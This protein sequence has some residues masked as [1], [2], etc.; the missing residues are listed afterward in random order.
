MTTTYD[1]AIIGGGLA[2]CSAAIRLGQRGLRV[3]L[4][5]ASD[6]PHHKVC[7]EFMSPGCRRQLDELGVAE[8][9]MHAGAA[10]ISESLISTPDGTHWQTQLP[11]AGIGISRHFLDE[12]LMQRAQ[13]VGVEV[14]TRTRIVKVEGSLDKGFTLHTRRRET[15]TAK[16]VIGA[17]GKRS[18][19][20]NALQRQFLQTR[21]P[22]VGL[23]QHAHNLPIPNRVELHTFEGGYCG[24]SEIEDGRTNICLLVRED[25]FRQRGNGSIE[26]FIDWMQ[27]Q[28]PLLAER[29]SRAELCWE[30]WL[31]IAQVPF[32]S[33][34]LVQDDVLM[35]G[36]AAGMITPLTGDGMEIALQSGELVAEHIYAY[37][38]QNRDAPQ[39]RRE[40]AAAWHAQFKSR[41]HIGRASQFFMLRPGWLRWALH[42]FNIAPP[43]G[44]F[45]VQHTRSTER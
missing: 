18:N 37:L 31:S 3:V 16:T 12:Q 15:L 35:S 1:V 42:A 13:T 39:L 2:G 28:N 4:C 19:V 8:A 7:G 23:K 6:Y 21:Q 34:S 22:F 10:R 41:I 33:K 9:V 30:R 38:C 27:A 20:D 43:V 25:V 29:L 40:Y 5:E 45:I 44:D 32:L 11:G 26:A 24:M 17:Y 36:D 14:R